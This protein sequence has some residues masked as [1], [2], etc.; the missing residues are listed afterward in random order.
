MG[1][2]AVSVGNPLAGRSIAA[3]QRP[4]PNGSSRWQ[5]FEV[6]AK[7]D[8]KYSSSRSALHTRRKV[9]EVSGADDG[10]ATAGANEILLSERLC[11]DSAPGVSE[12]AGTLAPLD[13]VK[14]LA[15]PRTGELGVVSEVKAGSCEVDEEWFAL[16]QVEFQF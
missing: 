12:A 8:E 16:S 7:F 10:V 1:A 11:V 9:D 15:G 14:I 13:T 4:Q 2:H 3:Y 6:S 5:P